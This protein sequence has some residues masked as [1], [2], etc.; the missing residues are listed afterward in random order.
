MPAEFL[1]AELQ[2]DGALLR[3]RESGQERQCR[4]GVLVN[5]AGPWVADVA[6]RVSPFTSQVRSDLVQGT[7]ILVDLPARDGILY[8]EVPEDG[9]AVFLV[10][11]KGMSLVG[12]TETAFAGRDPAATTPSPQEREYLRRV[13]EHYLPGQAFK[14]L[15][16]FSGLR[17]LP[18]EAERPFARGRELILET[19]RS[20]QPRL[21]NLYGGKLTS[22]RADS[23]K[24][25]RKIRNFLPER[26]VRAD[27]ARL[28][29]QP[30]D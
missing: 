22:Y 25:L 7:H 26:K 9:R 17:V 29:L 23:L 3:Y 12:T 15:G 21:I 27:T 2:A 28:P 1:G 11:W 6:A 30:V 5:A 20:R 10:P 16:A 24:V 13:V 19:D 8:M 14:E 4:A 18:R